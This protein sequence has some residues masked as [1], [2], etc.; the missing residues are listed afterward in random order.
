MNG[1]YSIHNITVAHEKTSLF[2][3]NNRFSNSIHLFQLVLFNYSIIKSISFHTIY[4]YIITQ[5]N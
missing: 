2:Q 3:V 1:L 5:G 4:I